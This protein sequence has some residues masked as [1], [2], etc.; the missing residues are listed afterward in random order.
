MI[1]FYIY[2]EYLINIYLYIRLFI[3]DKYKEI[4][5]MFY[6][7]LIINNISLKN[8]TKF[9]EKSI[10]I[11]NFIKNNSINWTLL[12][13][14]TGIQKSDFIIVDYEYKDNKYKLVIPYDVNV[15]LDSLDYDDS[16]LMHKKI[17]YAEYNKK[18]VTTRVKKFAG[19]QHNFYNDLDCYS[20]LNNIFS[21]LKEKCSL[22]I[23][24]SDGDTIL[25]NQ[26]DEIKI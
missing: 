3:Q 25:F 9:S 13:T 4:C 16:N 12:R 8:N 10:S 15:V 7:T 20:K 26:N 22:N 17:I 2:I 14:H 23:T 18:D 6:S 19:P 21:T 11:Q 1:N 5:R 24:L